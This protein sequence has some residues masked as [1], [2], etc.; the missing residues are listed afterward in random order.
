MYDPSRILPAMVLVAALV[1]GCAAPMGERAPV[2]D[3][4]PGESVPSRPESEP[5][6]V[7][8][9][10]VLELS[11]DA[12]AALRQGRFDNAAQLLERAIR[13][14]PHNGA[15]WHELAVVR[16]EQGA[17]EQAMQLANRSN[18]AASTGRSLR[19]EN[20]ALIE[21]SRKALSY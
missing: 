8:S 20:D 3:S 15:L 19:E 14:E 10:A 2:E 17:Y 6:P 7:N 9:P 13:I 4:T 1:A 11:G 21:K 18:A 16:F 5:Q 12:R